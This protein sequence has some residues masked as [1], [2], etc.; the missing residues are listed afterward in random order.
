MSTLSL[1]VDLSARSKI[2]TTSAASI[3]KTSAIWSVDRPII[4]HEL[5]IFYERMLLGPGMCTDVLDGIEYKKDFKLD[6]HSHDTAQRTGKS[7]LSLC[8]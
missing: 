8:A 6:G 2:F 4:P 5:Q 3:V 7:L 1:E